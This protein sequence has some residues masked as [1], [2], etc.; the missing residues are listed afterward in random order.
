M[1]SEF[2]MEALRAFL[3]RRLRQRVCGSGSWT[4]GR[5]KMLVAD[6]AFVAE[7]YAF[8]VHALVGYLDEPGTPRAVP[9][10]KGGNWITQAFGTLAQRVKPA[11]SL[12]SY[13]PP[14]LPVNWVTAAF[15]TLSGRPASC[16]T[17]VH[18]ALLKFAFMLPF[19]YFSGIHACNF[20]GRERERQKQRE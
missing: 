10:G 9:P 13:D 4:G 17:N 8:L 7:P 18:A 1:E 20:L 19:V 16:P 14:D 11:R 15:D 2:L 12:Q 3:R 6:C 5:L